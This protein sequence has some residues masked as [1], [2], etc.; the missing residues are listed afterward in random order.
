M[1]ARRTPAIIR[2]REFI[3]QIHRYSRDP[4]FEGK[5]ILLEDYDMSLAR[6]LV[7]GVDVC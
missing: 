5:I 1:P 4:L 7:T 6:K 2:D 3:R